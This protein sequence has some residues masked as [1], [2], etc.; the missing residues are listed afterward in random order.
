LP[1][2]FVPPRFSFTFSTQHQG[3]SAD[4]ESQESIFPLKLRASTLAVP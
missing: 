2:I 4:F 3:P 1:G